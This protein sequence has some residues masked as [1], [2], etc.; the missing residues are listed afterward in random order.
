MSSYFIQ[1]LG[2]NV[3]GLKL[4]VDL[5][6]L[7]ASHTFELDANG[8]ADGATFPDPINQSLF[9]TWTFTIDPADNL[10]FD[11]AGLADL[12]VFIEYDF[13]YKS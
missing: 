3:A 7:G 5:A 4:R 6:G 11:L 12:A 9:D 13:D 2:D 1:A 10:G 8:N